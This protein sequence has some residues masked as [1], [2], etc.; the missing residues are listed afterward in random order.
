MCFAQATD[1]GS[2]QLKI[3]AAR[4]VGANDQNGWCETGDGVVIE[5]SYGGQ[6]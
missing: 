1:V 4:G 5:T 2:R 6:V 3:S